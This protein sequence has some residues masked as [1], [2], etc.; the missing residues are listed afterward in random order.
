MHTNYMEKK[1]KQTNKALTTFKHK[2]NQTPRKTTTEA[3]TN[4][5]ANGVLGYNARWNYPVKA[6]V[7][8]STVAKPIGS[9]SLPHVKLLEMWGEL[10]LGLAG[11]A[12]G[13]KSMGLADLGQM[14]VLEKKKYQEILNCDQ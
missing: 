4:K 12:A 2:N 5:K 3:S 11:S 8:S 9:L 10:K 14:E 7:T 13:Q 6:L 1:K